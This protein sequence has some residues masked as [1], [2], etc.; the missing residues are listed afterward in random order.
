MFTTIGIN[1]FH[2]HFGHWL[3]QILLFIFF[4]IVVLYGKV[5]PFKNGQFVAHKCITV[6]VN[7]FNPILVDAFTDLSVDAMVWTVVPMTR[8]DVKFF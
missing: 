8:K 6:S 4:E 2:Y 5:Y 7:D 1:S 3:N